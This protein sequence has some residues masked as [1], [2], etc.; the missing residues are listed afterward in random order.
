M[1]DSMHRFY[2]TSI[3]LLIFLFLYSCNTSSKI[4]H[5]GVMYFTFMELNMEKYN[6]DT[7][8][9]DLNIN[10]KEGVVDMLSYEITL[11]K[12]ENDDWID[13]KSWNKE[14]YSDRYGD[15]KYVSIQAGGKYR[16]SAYLTAYHGTISET[17]QMYSN[18][19][20]F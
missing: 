6:N 10:G 19:I 1:I 20:V 7:V 12:W 13:I 4:A 8:L 5:S 18:T 11:Q 3:F 16:T 17:Q 2:R 14:I 9:V 15:S